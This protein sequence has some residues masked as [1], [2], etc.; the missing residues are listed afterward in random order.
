MT[1]RALVGLLAGREGLSPCGSSIPSRG[2]AHA[3]HCRRRPAAGRRSASRA[4]RSLRPRVRSSPPLRGHDEPHGHDAIVGR[5]CANPTIPHAPPASFSSTMSDTIGMCGHGTIGLAVT[6]AHMGRL[7]PPRIAGPGRRR[8][9]RA[10]STMP[11]DGRCR[12]CRFARRDRGYRVPGLRRRARDDTLRRNSFFLSIVHACNHVLESLGS[13]STEA[14]TAIHKH[15][16][17]RPP[18]QDGATD[19]PHR[20]LRPGAINNAERR[21]F[22]PLSQQGLQ[23]SPYRTEPAP[24]PASARRKV[25]ARR[26]LRAGG[27]QSAAAAP[28]SSNRSDRRRSP[29]VGGTRRLRRKR[30]SSR[31]PRPIP[32]RVVTQA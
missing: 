15:Y 19:R 2:R 29:R 21:Q 11:H 12:G 20:V 6:L 26:S 28:A 3:R 18:R 27:R 22:R 17:P 14:A 10:L 4:P 16:N 31:T 8:R 30:G 24:A 5:S 7:E 32:I 23:P 9:R 1:F 25:A 13:V